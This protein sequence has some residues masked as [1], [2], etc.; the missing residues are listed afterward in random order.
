MRLNETT[1]ALCHPDLDR[2][3]DRPRMTDSREANISAYSLEGG[4]ATRIRS[5]GREPARR[6]VDVVG[7]LL[8]LGLGERHGPGR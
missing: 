7:E 1:L 4:T 3:E 5:G 2:V 8:G 6:L